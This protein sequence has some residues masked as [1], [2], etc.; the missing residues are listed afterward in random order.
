M[1][2]LLLET[3]ILLGAQTSPT[4]A[5][6]LAATQIRFQHRDPVDRFLAATA[7]VEDLTLVTD[8]A[9][10]LRR[11]DILLMANGIN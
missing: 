8:D 4:T 5:I 7:K 9:Q 2:R 3:H 1:S 10:L 11:D 6:V